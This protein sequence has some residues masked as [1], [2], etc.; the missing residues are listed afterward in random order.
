[1]SDYIKALK[2]SK[3]INLK[4]LS[5]VDDGTGNKLGTDG[6]TVVEVVVT[7]PCDG[8]ENNDDED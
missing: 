2:Y 1:M 3:I 6:D 8:E 5:P 4:E 7:I